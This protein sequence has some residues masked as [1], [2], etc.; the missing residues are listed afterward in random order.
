MKVYEI[1]PGQLYQRG[2]FSHF[3]NSVKEEALRARNIGL[4]VGLAGPSDTFLEGLAEVRYLYIPIPD[5]RFSPWRARVIENTADIVANFVFVDRIQR[6]VLVYC[7][8][9]RNRSSL[10]NALVIMRLLRVDG[11]E[12]AAH[13]IARR[14]NALSN[15]EWKDYLV[16]RRIL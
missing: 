9:G 16:R 7:N 13:V 14:P 2:R 11:A 1:L 5:G 8:A 12:A 15:V 6:A 10:L 3:S 4:V